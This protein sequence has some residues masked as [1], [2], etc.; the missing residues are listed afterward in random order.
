MPDVAT[1]EA[2]EAPTPSDGGEFSAEAIAKKPEMQAVFDRVFGDGGQSG[3]GK[4]P[5]AASRAE[6]TRE[7]EEA[8][9]LE[10]VDVD[11]DEPGQDGDDEDGGA[12][13]AGKDAEPGRDVEEE[14]VEKA[15]DSTLSPVLR[16][17]ALRA[18]MSSEEI[19]EAHKGNPEL[20]ERL[21]GKLLANFNDLS[22]AYGRMGQP[23]NQYTPPPTQQQP[24]AQ[25]PPAANAQDEDLLTRLYGGNKNIQALKEKY[26]EEA[27][28]DLIKPLTGPLQEMMSMMDDQR[29]DAMAREVNGYFS[30]LD[31]DFVEL[32]GAQDEVTEEQRETRLKVCQ[33]ADQIRDGASRQGIELRVSECLDRANMMHASE[34]LGSLE[35]KKILSEVK[36]KRSRQLTARPSQRA[37]RSS[38]D[39]PRSKEKAMD[40]F[41][42]RAQ[43]LGVNLTE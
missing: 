43:E 41:A 24:P 16:Q 37:G 7:E 29:T 27:M 34:H 6:R 20:S 8:E 4:T 9:E 39:R 10:T 22:T 38:A 36:N 28:E 33:L 18:G 14:P 26:G 42:A 31:K 30:A 13:A 5:T 35:R 12:E 17:A 32:Y 23:V 15:V 3:E 2:T 11:E 25:A 1:V 40:A 21:F 19:E